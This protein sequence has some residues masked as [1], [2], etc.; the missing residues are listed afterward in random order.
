MIKQL[1]VVG[2][3]CLSLLF[4]SCKEDKPVD[5]DPVVGGGLIAHYAMDGD[6]QDASVR[7]KMV[8]PYAGTMTTMLAFS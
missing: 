5:P 6:G 2:L 8:G 4:T 3:A 7:F 1:T